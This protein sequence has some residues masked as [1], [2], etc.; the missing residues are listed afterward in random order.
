MNYRIFPVSAI[1]VLLTC[2]LAGQSFNEK[3]DYHKSL[4]VTREMS[5]DVSNKYGTI[6]ITPWNKDSVSVKVEVEANSSSLERL[7]KLFGGINVNIT[8]STFQVRAETEFSQTI[9]I[10]FESFKGLTNKIIPYESRLQ[11]NYFI[12]AP[13]YMDMNISN[14]YGDVYM[15]DNTGKFSLSLSNGSF[16]ANSL[17]ESGEIELTF[18]DATIN[19]IKKGYLNV[20]FSDVEVGESQDL[21]INSI[22]S[23]FD[24]KKAG[25]IDAESRRDK[26]YIGTVSEVRGNSYFTDYR[27]GELEKELDVVSKYGSLNASIIE[28]GL[29]M[30]SINS[31]YSDLSL[32][33]DP[34]VSYNLDIR[35]ANAFVVLPEKN[36]DIEKKTINEDKKEYNFFGKVGRNPGNVK[37]SIDATHGNIYIK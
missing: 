2:S 6:H 22:S 35:Q 34:S 15:E 36:T 26:F 14:K 27:I 19:K 11:I 29:D 3:K 18:C 9:D 1:A 37:V 10:L 25:K 30:I 12:S 23:R 21:K 20:S 16:K 17:N 33:F 8:S 5:L 4:P 24:L 32:N 13:E 7:H 31:S 28:K